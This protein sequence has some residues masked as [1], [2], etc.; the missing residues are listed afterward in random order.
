MK[1]NVLIVQN[2]NI[3][4]GDTSV[5]FAMKKSL[6][7]MY[8]DLTINLTSYDSVKAKKEYDLNSA[9]WLLDYRMIKKNNSKIGKIFYFLGFGL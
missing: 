3:N 4:K 9:E 8:P 6:L 7:D 1:K 5:I 2:Y